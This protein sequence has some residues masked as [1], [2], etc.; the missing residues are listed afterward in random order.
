MLRQADAIDMQEGLLA[1]Q[2]YHDVMAQMSQQYSIEIEKVI[3]VF[4]STSPNNDYV[5]N[6]RSTISILAGIY[7]GVPEEQVTISRYKHCRARAWQYATG[8]RNFLR[9]TKGPKVINFYH[10]IL[11]PT[12]NRYVTIDG[13]M[14]AIWQNK[15]LT[16]KEALI[17][18]GEY[19][20]ISA[21]V[22]KLAFREMMLPNQL[23]AILWFT[24]KR[25]CNIKSEN[26]FDLLLPKGDLWKT[27]RNIK[28]LK[29]Y[30]CSLSS[31]KTL[32]SSTASQSQGQ[33]ALSDPTG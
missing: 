2:R 23:Q 3:A 27:S 24:R 9:E 25:V 8:Q 19:N 10:N 16:M 1:Y 31:I 18:K 15:N 4:V 12:D 14:S 17:S 28:D 20:E 7:H 32:S 5:N 22:K 11:D 30:P 26:Q 21:A 6:L 13:H 33:L 29:P